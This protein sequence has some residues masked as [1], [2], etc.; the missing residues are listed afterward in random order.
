MHPDYDHQP[1]HDASHDSETRFGPRPAFAGHEGPISHRSTAVPTVWGWV[2]AGVAAAAVTAGTVLALRKV[3]DMITS[4]EAAPRQNLAPRF[5]TLDD[6]EREDM[7]RNVRARAREDAAE[8]ARLRA[9]A[10]RRR[11]MPQPNVADRFTNR[12]ER[13][14]GSLTAFVAAMSGAVEGFRSVAGQAGGIMRD[15][16]EAAATVRSFLDGQN[17]GGNV[18]RRSAQ[19]AAARPDRPDLR[20]DPDSIRRHNL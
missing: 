19:G 8:A 14:S 9:A 10:G 20:A 12:A 4:D 13:V 1:T 11:A 7:R 18:D 17:G 16:T 2:G 15:F 3:A 5:A 6:D